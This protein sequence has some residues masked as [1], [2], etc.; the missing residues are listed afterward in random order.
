[1]DRHFN[2]VHCASRVRAEDRLAMIR[3][4]LDRSGARGV[5]FVVQKFCT[6]HLAVIPAKAG[7]QGLF[8]FFLE[9]YVL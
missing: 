8:L 3:N 9:S 2:R 1:M 4:L 7:I 6:P 5:L